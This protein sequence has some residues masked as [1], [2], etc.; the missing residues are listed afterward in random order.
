MYVAKKGAPLFG[1]IH[2]T[3]MGMQLHPGA[4]QQV[5]LVGATAQEESIVH[6]FPEVLS[7]KLGKLKGFK[8][9][10]VLRW[11]YQH[12]VHKAHTLPLAV[13]DDVKSE[14]TKLNGAPIIEEIE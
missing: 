12:K 10:I 13:R 8:H 3:A 4:K 1:L 6:M 14:I 11:G 7:E 9:Q 5:V 2:Q